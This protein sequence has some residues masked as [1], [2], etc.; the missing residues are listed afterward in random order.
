MLK[1]L[2]STK[3]KGIGKISIGNVKSAGGMWENT[4]SNSLL[5]M[6][7]PMYNEAAN[8]AHRMGVHYDTGGAFGKPVSLKATIINMG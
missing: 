7:R 3:I 8:L 5:F 4:S 2:L 6:E 1:M